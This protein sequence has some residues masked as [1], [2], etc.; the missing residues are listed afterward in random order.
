MKWHLLDDRG[1]VRS[2]ATAPDKRTAQAIL[3]PGPVVSAISYTMDARYTPVLPRTE[4]GAV[5]LAAIKRLTPKAK[6]NDGYL[7]TEEVAKTL[8]VNPQRVRAF[9]RYCGLTPS[10]VSGRRSRETF[11]WDR[12]QVAAMRR[13]YDDQPPV[14]LHPK[15]QAKRRAAL[16]LANAKRWGWIDPKSPT[17]TTESR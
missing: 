10:R 6:T 8:G 17:P 11:I 5:S 9:A 7:T 14:G 16:L 2:T 12:E 4:D 15:A 3:G 1:R 13:Y